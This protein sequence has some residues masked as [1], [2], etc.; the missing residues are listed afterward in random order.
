[1]EKPNYFIKVIMPI[2]II[3]AMLFILTVVFSGCRARPYAPNNNYSGPPAPKDSF[4][5]KP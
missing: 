1:M 3:A 5:H 4:L 2:V